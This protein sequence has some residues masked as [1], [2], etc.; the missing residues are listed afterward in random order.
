MA[1]PVKDLLASLSPMSRKIVLALARGRMDTSEIAAAIYTDREPPRMARDSIR[2]EIRRLRAKLEPHGLEVACIEG[3]RLGYELRRLRPAPV[4]PPYG[5]VTQ[6]IV[7][8]LADHGP[9]GSH[10]IAERIYQGRKLRRP[11]AAVVMLICRHREALEKAGIRIVSTG[12]RRSVYKLE[13][14]A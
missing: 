5:I 11:H 13:R 12:G 6:Q 1:D 7:N 8:V 4:R 14:V 2:A 3:S 10:E 9:M